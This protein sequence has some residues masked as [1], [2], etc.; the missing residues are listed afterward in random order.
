MT[1]LY[2]QNKYQL[3]QMGSNYGA[4]QTVQTPP[5]TQMD[6]AGRVWEFNPSGHGGEGA[7]GQV[8]PTWQ[9]YL[10][11]FMGQIGGGGG[12]TPAP[13]LP[14]REAAPQV[15]AV[16]PSQSEAFGRAKD[17]SSRF[18]GAAMEQLKDQMTA[19]GISGSGVEGREMASLMGG[20]ARYQSDA[21]LQQQL[22]AQR[23]AWEAAKGGYEGAI[24][25]RGQDISGLTSIY[26]TQND[27]LRSLLDLVGKF[28]GGGVSGIP[29]STIPTPKPTTPTA[30]GGL[31][32]PFLG[33]L[34]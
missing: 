6:A 5:A 29:T 1:G 12:A 23:Q 8:T 34:Y 17:A 9:K 19:A 24:E 4:F 15:K 26:A 33:R 2:S 28:G 3:P 7:W 10:D 21:E 22:E 16:A 32:T 13:G 14:G 27:K 18:Y 31:T 11:A 30:G 20:A 25:Q